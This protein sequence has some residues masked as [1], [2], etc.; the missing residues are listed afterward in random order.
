MALSPTQLA[1]LREI[2]KGPMPRT[3]WLRFD[4]RTRQSLKRQNLT[5]YVGTHVVLSEEGRKALED[6]EKPKRGRG[7]PKKDTN[8]EG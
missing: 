2:I 5:T 3:Q 4:G 1:L 7:R 8:P 6:A